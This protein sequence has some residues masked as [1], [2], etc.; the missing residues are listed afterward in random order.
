MKGSS[1]PPKLFVAPP[2]LPWFVGAAGIG[3]CA[4]TGS[5]ADGAD[6]F[7]PPKSSSAVTLGFAGSAAP[8]PPPKALSLESPHPPEEL[9]PKAFVAAV[10]ELPPNALVVAV[11]DEPQPSWLL[12]L[13]G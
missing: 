6:E 10:E 4:L 2:P 7:H 5:G 9:A 11:V 3:A 8:K 12:V 1:P 13:V